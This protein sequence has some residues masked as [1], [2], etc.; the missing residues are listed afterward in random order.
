MEDNYMYQWGDLKNSIL[1]KLDIDEDEANTMGLL[2]RF[3]IYANEAMTQIC[4]TVKPKRT[5]Y[6]FVIDEP[7]TKIIMPEDFVSFGDAVPS[8][9]S[10]GQ[11]I[12]NRVIKLQPNMN[13]KDI[14]FKENISSEDLD[15]IS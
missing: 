14:G 10:K 1:S 7:N 11:K 5:Y 9:N 4:S 2:N 12:K 13:L 15:F 6:E 3:L 8:Y